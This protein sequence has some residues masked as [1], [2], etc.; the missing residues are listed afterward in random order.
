MAKVEPYV[1]KIKPS[2]LHRPSRGHDEEASKTAISSA[3]I[4]GRATRSRLRRSSLWL[5]VRFIEPREGIAVQAVIHARR[6]LKMHAAE[7][8]AKWT[9]LVQL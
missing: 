9:A 7:T 8:P 3:N 4:L 5:I 1:A 2:G 6:V